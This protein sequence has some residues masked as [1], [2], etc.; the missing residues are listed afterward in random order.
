MKIDKVIQEDRQAKLTVEYPKDVFEGF[1]RRAAKKIAK[2]ATIPGF[3]PGKAS[4]QVVLSHYGEGS[5]IQ[6]AID[7][8]LDDDYA[9]IL[10]Q[11]G[12]KPSGSGNL[13]SIESYD[14]PKFVFMIPLEPE[15]DLG[16]YKEIR[17]EYQLVEFDIKEVDD[18][19]DNMRRN[20]ATIIPASHPAKEGNL[21]YF[22][23]SGEFLNPKEDEDASITEKINQQVL[24]PAADEDPGN[25]WPYPGFSRELLGVKDGD[26]KEIQH[27]FPKDHENEEYQGKTGLFNVEVQSV[28]ELE[29][30]VFDEDF[31]QTLGSDDSPEEFREK[32]EA[33]LRDQHQITY[34]QEYFDDL[35]NEITEQ[36]KMTYPPQMLEHEEEHVLE[37]VKSRLE[38]QGMNFETYVKIRSKDEETFKEEEIRP[39]AKQRLERSLVVDALIEA[40]DLK[41]NQEMLKENLNNVMSEM[42][43]SGDM[44]EM[45]KEMG[46]EQFSRT[47]SMESFQRTMNEQLQ[48][49]LKLIATGQPIPDEESENDAPD[50]VLTEEDT[51]EASQSDEDLIENADDVEDELNVSEEMSTESKDAAVEEPSDEDE[52]EESED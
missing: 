40:E 32:V 19:I 4:Y 43:Y 21:I 51:D 18:F 49:R 25:E 48:E 29:L 3:R 13:E 47:I 38:K 5:I 7:I 30:P 36:T 34:D 33:R 8:L 11:E 39:V 45:Q 35:F 10:D 15:V 17:K 44:A 16:D 28:K 26:T 14:P 9:K 41:L 27:T 6:E 1:K 42:V 24:I 52:A 50:E 31:V 22:N 37:D 2:N 12:I 20:A 23:L 46:K